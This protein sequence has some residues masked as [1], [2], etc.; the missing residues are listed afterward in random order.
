MHFGPL[1][2]ACSA[3]FLGAALYS[4]LVEQ[5][6]RL[7]LDDRAMVREWAPSDR[8]GVAMLAGFALASA[9]C[10]LLEFRAGGDVRWLIGAAFVI[11]SWPYT[12]FVVVP[13][14]NRL[15][16]EADA[17]G[18]RGLVAAWGLLEWGQA[19]LGLIASAVFIWAVG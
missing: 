6:A 16:S 5:P 7:A 9:I 2:L 8:A 14:N 13:I 11:A 12:F 4:V 3:A 18:A 10:A 17:P 1:A 15:L 19:A